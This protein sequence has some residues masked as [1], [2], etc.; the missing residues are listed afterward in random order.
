[1]E[2]SN[3]PAPALVQSVVQHARSL[4]IDGQWVAPSTAAEIDVVNPATESAFATIGVANAADVDAA[5]AAARRAFETYAFSS[6]DERIALLERIIAGYEE[7]LEDFAQTISL[8]M[9]API[10]LA[11]S[12]QAPSGLGHFKATLAALRE[13][14]FEERIGTTTVVFE[15]V[16]VCGMITP[17]NWPLFQ[18]AAKIAPALAT[19]CTMVLKPSELAPLSAL[20]LTEV[21]DAAGVPA[22]VFNLVQGDG[23][24]VGA[25]LASHPDIDMISFT[26]STRVG[27]EVS[28]R[29]AENV[30]RVA[31]ELGGKS[32]NIV[33]A[34][35]DLEAVMLRDVPKMYGNSGQSCN[36]GT[37]IIVPADRMDE[38]AE[39]ARKVF[40]GATVGQP[41]V[42]ETVLGPV[43]SQAQYDKVQNLIQSGIDEGATLVTGGRGRP[44]GVETG[45]YVRPTVFA[46]VRNDMRIAR[47]EIFGPVLSLIPYE[48]ED[49]AIRIANDSDYGLAGMVSSGDQARARAVARRMR[50]GMVHLNGASMNPD[51]PFG[52]Y[53]KSGNGREF[54]AHGMKEYLEAKSL[55]GDAS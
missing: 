9:G 21:L 47:E 31:L 7:R 1:M 17:W 13:T 27:V 6:R 54:G 20:I 30:K 8:E 24:S 37:R 46:N 28:Q 15:P 50:T 45:Y 10:T 11:R 51:A 4:F 29:A 32:A 5:V 38:A 53:K 34:D 35:A 48:T 52:G 16:G 26:G 36:A 25:A 40:E 12:K 41:E 3:P 49:E 2:A 14:T 44:D 43:V 33:L 19:G 22:G 55:F 42:P 23:P 39:L 18:T